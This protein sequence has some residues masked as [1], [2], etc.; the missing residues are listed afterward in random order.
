MIQALAKLNYYE[1][2]LNAMQPEKLSEK[3]RKRIIE[4]YNE[5]KEMPKIIGTH[6]TEQEKTKG[7]ESQILN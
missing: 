1:G 6:K 7:A 5:E 3:D 4:T 2:R